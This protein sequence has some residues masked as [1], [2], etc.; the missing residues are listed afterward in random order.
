MSLHISGVEKWL[1]ENGNP[2]FSYLQS[3]AKE[4]TLDSLEKLRSIADDHNANYENGD[5][6]Q[7]LVDMIVSAMKKEDGGSST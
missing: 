7:V 2:N 6:A 5:S 4:E 3:L 1:D